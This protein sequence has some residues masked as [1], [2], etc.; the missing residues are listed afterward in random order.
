MTMIRDSHFPRSIWRVIR[1]SPT[2]G[3]WN[4]AVDEAVLEAVGRGEVAPT[5]RLYAWQPACL[6]LGY[7]Q[8]VSDVDFQA[9]AVQGW[10]LVRRPTGGRAILHTDE[11]TYSVI[12]PQSEPRLLGGVLESYQVLS[13]ALLQ[14][15]QNLNIPA[16]ALEKPL[17]PRGSDPKGP[18]CFEVP[19][20]YE[21]TVE[22]KKL[23]GSAQARRKQGVLQHGSLPL[24]GDL[25]RITRALIFRDEAER[26]AVA[27]RLLQRAT[28]AELILGRPLDWE[29]AARAFESAFTEALNL[30]LQVGVLTPAELEQAQ[31]LVANKYASKEWTGRV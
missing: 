17:P 2:H 29:S 19:S 23:I 25:T 1:T 8:S 16:Q 12:G 11:L 14:A 13:A 5:L 7:A 3:A 21:I 9:L 31:E 4:M 20:N 6:S 10:E 26:S 15:L 22:G 28:T 24:Y 30:E 27:Q 18:V